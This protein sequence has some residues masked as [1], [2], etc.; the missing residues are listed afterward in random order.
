MEY[1]HNATATL[2]GYYLGISQN[3]KNNAGRKE[4]VYDGIKISGDIFCS[5]DNFHMST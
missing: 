1:E 3:Y 4:N 5:C 2:C